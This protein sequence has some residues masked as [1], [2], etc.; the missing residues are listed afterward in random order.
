MIYRPHLIF[1]N[2]HGRI[3]SNL[4][5]VFQF[6]PSLLGDSNGKVS[7]GLH[8]NNTLHNNCIEKN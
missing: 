6:G 7:F 3:V 8:N 2:K 5:I 1:S 4:G